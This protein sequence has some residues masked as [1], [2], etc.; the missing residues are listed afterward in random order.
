[1]GGLSARPRLVRRVVARPIPWARGLDGR[2]AR[3][4]WS[5]RRP[6]R[7]AEPRLSRSLLAGERSQGRWRTG[8]GKRPARRAIRTRGQLLEGSKTTMAGRMSRG[9][10]PRRMMRTR[11]TW[12]RRRTRVPR[13][14]NR[15][16]NRM[17]GDARSS[18]RTS[19]RAG[20]HQ[21]LPRMTGRSWA[22]LMSRSRCG[23]TKA[24]GRSRL[25]NCWMTRTLVERSMWPTCRR[26]NRRRCCGRF[27]T[28]EWAKA[29]GWSRAARP[30]WTPI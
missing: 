8:R 9:L 20:Q 2:L 28:P 1:M 26:T 3:G 14:S 22:G 12:N 21:R 6:G 18:M 24:T 23:T 30:L 13:T 19:F 10:P 5:R 15:R 29:S 16:M 4:R 25:R 17:R 7:R 27:P 11:R